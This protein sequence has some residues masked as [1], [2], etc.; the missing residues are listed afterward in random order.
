MDLS[1]ED[2]SR[3]GTLNKF[4][5]LILR[6]LPNLVRPAYAKFSLPELGSFAQI[7]TCL[8]FRENTS[9]E[10]ILYRPCSE[11]VVS[12]TYHSYRERR[13]ASQLQLSPSAL[14]AR[15]HCFIPS[16]RLRT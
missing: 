2:S 14:F 8:H 1:G 12:L 4:K 9:S 11:L 5:Q 13:E 10:Q 16:R 15:A 3:Q 7:S 6:V